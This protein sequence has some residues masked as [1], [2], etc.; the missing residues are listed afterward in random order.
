MKGQVWLHFSMKLWG[1]GLGESRG[2][3][4]VLVPSQG[5]CEDEGC[6]RGLFLTSASTKEGRKSWRSF[7]LQNC[8]AVVSP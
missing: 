7:L 6:Q 5:G 1:M 4:N 8:A 2:C 3:E